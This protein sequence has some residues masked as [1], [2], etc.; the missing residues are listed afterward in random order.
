MFC[1]LKDEI[2]TVSTQLDSL[3][4]VNQKNQNTVSEL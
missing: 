3:V 2:Y 1:V 4:G